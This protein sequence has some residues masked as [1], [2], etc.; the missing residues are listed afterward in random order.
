MIIKSYA[1]AG[2]EVISIPESI[3]PMEGF[4][5]KLDD[6]HARVF[7]FKAQKNWVVVSL[8]MTSLQDYEIDILKENIKNLLHVEKE[9]IWITV[10]HTFSAPHIRSVHAL[11]D[12]FIKKK[13]TVYSN[14][15]ENAVEAACLKAVQSMK[16]VVV[17]YGQGQCNINRNRDIETNEGW[18]LGKNSEGFSDMALP[19]ITFKD[20]ADNVIAVLYN[21]DMQSSV[22]DGVCLDDGTRLITSDVVGKASR[23]IEE[24][25]NTVAIYLLGAAGDQIPQLKAIE[26]SVIDG[27]LVE[28]NYKEKGYE[29]VEELG[30][31]L[32]KQVIS[33]M[34]AITYRD[35]L[36]MKHQK[37]FC[38]CNGQ[39][40]PKN[41][42]ELRPVR[43]Y[44][45]EED[46]VYKTPI[47]LIR[48][49][50]LA[51]IALQPEI[52]SQTAYQIRRESLF[53]FTM[54]V[55]MVNGGAKYMA[56]AKSYERITYEA[57]NSKF[58]KGSAEKV[59]DKAIEMLERRED[60]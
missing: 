24:N 37:D 46:G 17:G 4:G 58:A 56:D 51:I 8:E 28:I 52:C 38:Q 53:P 55:T 13:N 45:F 16:E 25:N 29:F 50:D 1:G 49:D 14:A 6:L 57:M 7:I 5:K 19:V 35:S 36:V 41:M 59:R 60:I 23:F 22:M 21:Y 2:K 27:K 18:W 3:F 12:D 33:V 54:V 30:K 32:G 10:T 40:A 11:Q 48:I 9:S 47:E 43:E 26:K 44:N 39:K 15:I 31:K 20:K 34:S 42:K